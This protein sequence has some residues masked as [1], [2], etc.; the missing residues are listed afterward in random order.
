MCL[1]TP[2][3]FLIFDRPHLT[4]RVFAEIARQKP[5]ELYVVCDGAKP[6]DEISAANVDRTRKIVE[7]VDWNCDVKSNFSDSNLGCKR[8]VSSGLKWVFEQVERAIILEDDCLPDPSFFGYCESLLERYA[9]D[10]RVSAISGNNFQFGRSRTDASYYFSKY[11]H[12]WGWATWR[13]AWNLLD[14]DC[15]PLPIRRAKSN[16]GPTFSIRNSKIKL[17]HGIFLGPLRAFFTVA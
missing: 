13:H 12:C 6:A 15:W 11:A 4:E 16:S 1:Q 3:A 8:R 7:R 5:R 14:L 10:S 17:T 2:V 9:D